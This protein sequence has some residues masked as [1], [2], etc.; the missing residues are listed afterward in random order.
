M[1]IDELLLQAHQA[2]LAARGPALGHRMEWAQIS[3]IDRLE[4]A[5]RKARAGARPGGMPGKAVRA[6]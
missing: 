1:M 3:R 2:D 6:E 4:R 5:L